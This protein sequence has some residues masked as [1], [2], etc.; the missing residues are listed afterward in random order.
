ME[1]WDFTRKQDIVVNRH[2][3]HHR[4]LGEFKLSRIR[5]ILVIRRM[6]LSDAVTKLTNDKKQRTI[7]VHDEV[8]GAG[9]RTHVEK[10]GSHHS[11]FPWRLGLSATPEREYDV[12]GNVFVSNEIGPVI[13]KFPLEK[14]IKR[15]ILCS[16]DYVP[17]EY[18][19]TVKDRQRIRQVYR[20]QTALKKQGTPMTQ[21]Q[22]WIEIAN[23]KKTAELKPSVF[24]DYLKEHSEILRGCIIFV[25]NI[26]Y[27]N[28]I[29]STIHNYTDKYRTYYAGED[30]EY[31]KTFARGKIDCLITC[32]RL[33]QGIDIRS[34]KN[35]VLFSSSKSKLETIQR[36]GRCLRIDPSNPAKRPN[37][38]DFVDSS[39]KS[40]Y[41]TDT[42]RAL[43][44]TKLSRIN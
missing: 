37:V 23:V 27:G 33:S 14:A 26:E 24:A 32:H 38:I 41:N 20:K 6:S 7:I 16:F 39:K 18:E 30:Q 34:L 42:E 40:D 8:H 28:R 3:G 21:E 11:K 12:K 19:L 31:L 2:F 44:L 4:E 1:S 17:L 15:N 36:I 9:M 25:E 35:I 29:L 5:S 10:M 22:V 13:F 43:W